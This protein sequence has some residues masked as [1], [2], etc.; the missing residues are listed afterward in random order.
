MDRRE[1]RELVSSLARKFRSGTTVP[2]EGE[3]IYFLKQILPSSK[4]RITRTTTVFKMGST[5]DENSSLGRNVRSLILCPSLSS[6]FTNP[7]S[8]QLPKTWQLIRSQEMYRFF[9]APKS[10]QAACD[11]PALTLPPSWYKL[12]NKDA[13]PA[14]VKRPGWLMCE[15]LK[16]LVVP[17]HDVSERRV[18]WYMVQLSVRWSSLDLSYSDLPSSIS[19]ILNLHSFQRLF[20]P[21]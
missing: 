6:Y 9:G 21:E 3:L 1:N 11:R 14:N 8:Y 18:R 10:M 17:L 4:Y 5:G 20:L 16:L 12:H 15:R 2:L 13:Y 7:Y 19:S